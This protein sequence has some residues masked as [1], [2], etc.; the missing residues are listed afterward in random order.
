MIVYI[1]SPGQVSRADNPTPRAGCFQVPARRWS[2]RSRNVPV[3]VCHRRKSYRQH[4]NSTAMRQQAWQMQDGT[5]TRQAAQRAWPRVNR[6]N[7]SFCTG[8]GEAIV[9]LCRMDNHQPVPLTVRSRF[10]LGGLGEE[11]AVTLP[12]VTVARGRGSNA[13]GACKPARPRTEFREERALTPS[14][15]LSALNNWE[16]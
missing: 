9:P 4:S 3:S 10:G 15:R 11:W 12:S 16:R 6:P 8:R 5:A 2:T 14:T 1:P 7:A 13:S